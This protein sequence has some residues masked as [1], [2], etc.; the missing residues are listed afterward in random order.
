MW[1]GESVR[2]FSLSSPQFLEPH[3][4]AR[5]RSG[6]HSAVM[7]DAG[8][9][10]LDGVALRVIGD[11]PMPGTAVKVW[12]SQAG[13]FVCAEDDE[14]QRAE[15]ARQDEEAQRADL[16][17]KHLNDRRADAESFNAQIK[18]PVKWDVGIKDVLSGL[19]ECSMGDGRS[20]TTVDHIYLLEPLQDG[21]M[22]RKAGDLLCTSVA[23]SNGKRW[24]SKVVERSFDG[25]GRPFQ[26]M[27]TCKACLNRASKWMATSEAIEKVQ[28]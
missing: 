18:L 22:V 10:L 3:W 12:I 26:P 5:V 23:G 9:V 15:R 1:P 7:D 14:I 17:R 25:D 27:V 21:R 24:S 6:Q 28:S 4:F 11:A 2:T 20:K 19:S 8:S 16:R 13:F